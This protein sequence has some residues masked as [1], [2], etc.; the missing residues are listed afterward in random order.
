M[1]GARA[2]QRLG[3]TAGA[4][5]MLELDRREASMYASRSPES[6]PKPQDV[7]VGFVPAPLHVVFGHSAAS[8]TFRPRSVPGCRRLGAGFP[9]RGRRLCTSRCGLCTGHDTEQVFGLC[10]VGHPPRIDSGRPDS[11]RLASLGPG[12]PAPPPR[13]RPGHEF[14]R[15]LARQ[16]LSARDAQNGAGFSPGASSA[17]G[18]VDLRSG[19]AARE[20]GHDRSGA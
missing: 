10:G 16:P 5:A 14:R 11:C 19:A 15:I 18:E 3:P 9:R 4:G 1:S 7:V 20:R 13:A 17:G 12:S 2:G 8:S 6:R